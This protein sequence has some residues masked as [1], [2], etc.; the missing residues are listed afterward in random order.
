LSIQPSLSNSSIVNDISVLK[1][2][3]QLVRFDSHGF[4]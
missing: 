2:T 4:D 1:N 3:H